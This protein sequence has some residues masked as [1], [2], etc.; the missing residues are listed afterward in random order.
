ML[1][2]RCRASSHLSYEDRRNIANIYV[3]PY[4]KCLSAETIGKT[5]VIDWIK[6]LHSCYTI[7]TEYRQRAKSLLQSAKQRACC[8]VY[9]RRPLVINQYQ[10]TPFPW[11]LEPGEV[12]TDVSFLAVTI[13]NTKETNLSIQLD[14]SRWNWHWGGGVSAVPTPT[15][16]CT[17]QFTSVPWVYLTQHCSETSEGGYNLMI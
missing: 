5:K 4:F 9:K 7:Q 15:S 11:E 14:G 6:W 16:V 13:T 8:S 12:V 1:N 10:F 3:L 17:H 2:S